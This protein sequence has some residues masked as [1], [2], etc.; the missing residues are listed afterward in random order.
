MKKADYCD[1]PTY[2]VEELDNVI[3]GEIKKLK[4]DPEYLRSLVDSDDTAPEDNAIKVL[5][6]ELETVKKKID[7]LMDLYTLGTIPIEDIGDKLKP[8]YEQK[9]KLEKSI[10]EGQKEKTSPSKLSIGEVEDILNN[11]CDLDNEELSVKREIVQALIKRIELGNE[12]DTL[13]IYWKFN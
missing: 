1:N 11:I 4:L 12:R 3:L 8:L 13:K 5:I 2:R 9:D 6:G 7:K 10:T